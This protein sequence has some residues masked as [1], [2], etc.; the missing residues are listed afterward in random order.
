MCVVSMVH[1]Y[2]APKLED[3]SLPKLDIPK[4]L[5]DFRRAQEAAQT[6]DTLTGQPDCVDPEKAKLEARVAEL[7]AE[8]AALK[9]LPKDPTRTTENVR[10]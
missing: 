6:V 2:Y 8:L 9:G 7:E 3:L 5:E 10:R 1:D 4:L